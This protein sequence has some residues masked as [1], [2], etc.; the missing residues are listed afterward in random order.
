M[1]I[2]RI[3]VIGAGQMGNGIAHVLALAGFDVV[4][5]DIN[6][7]TLAKALARIDRNMHRQAGRGLI[8]DEQLASALKRIRINQALDDL[9]DSDLVLEEATEDAATEQKI[10]RHLYPRL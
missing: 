6:K 2:E 8:K 3:G 9:K 5:D 7:E 1:S 10:F 4:L